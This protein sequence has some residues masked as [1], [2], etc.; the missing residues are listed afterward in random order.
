MTL[1]KRYP[2]TI[3]L[4]IVWLLSSCATSAKLSAQ[5]RSLPYGEHWAGIKFNSLPSGYSH[6]SIRN[7]A[8][9]VMINTEAFLHFFYLS[10]S[11]R[12]SM[13]GSD[14]VAHDLSLQGF[15]YQYDVDNSQIVLRGERSGRGLTVTMSYNGQQSEMVYDQFKE[16]YP[17]SAIN[18]YPLLHGLKV[19]AEYRYQVYDGESR[20]VIDVVQRVEAKEGLQG[21]SQPLYKVVANYG[22]MDVIRWV[23]EQGVSL[24]E[25]AMNGLFVSDSMSEAKAK[26]YLSQ[27]MLNKQESLLELSMIKLNKPIAYPMH[28]RFMSFKLLGL[29]NY[30]LSLD[31]QW[32]RCQKHA[33]ELRCEIDARGSRGPGLSAADRSRYLKDSVAIPASNPVIGNALQGIVNGQ[34]SDA[35]K[36]VV[37]LRWI[38]RNIKQKMVDVFSAIDVL[39]RRE[40]ECQGHSFLFVAWMR[41]SGI[42][43]RIVN[44]LVYSQQHQAFLYHTWAEVWLEQRWQAV[45]PTFGQRNADA[46][47]IKL[48]EGDSPEALAP[49][50]GMVG[51]IG[52]EV[53]SVE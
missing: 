2:Y 48:L 47:H 23:N 8:G 29:N 5:E 6:T 44:G 20:A 28:S 43:A 16:I 34:Q 45:D 17:V 41:A 13:Q 21:V 49:M 36:V 3:L 22:G 1:V 19:G 4:L 39:E 10:Q 31:D 9:S 52:V 37:V 46:T 38:E 24:I 15:Q 51:R 42:P 27:S 50:A 35:E 7:K 33:T 26:S 14:V 25:H 53:I 12:I 32:Q 18:F 40:A 30:T 11:K